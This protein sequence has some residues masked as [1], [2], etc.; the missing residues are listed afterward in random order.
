[1][2]RGKGALDREGSAGGPRTSRPRLA[3]REAEG[4]RDGLDEGDRQ[5]LGHEGSDVDDADG[6][7][8]ALGAVEGVRRGERRRLA[9]GRA[10]ARED[11]ERLGDELCE[12]REIPGVSETVGRQ[13]SEARGFPSGGRG[14]GCGTSFDDANCPVRR[15]ATPNL[16]RYFIGYCLFARDARRGAVLT[17]ALTRQCGCDT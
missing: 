4:H 1:M 17:P 3:S 10:R 9:A 8:G 12:G 16:D 14:G 15:L 13:S 5:V 11:E 6:G 7:V 2:P